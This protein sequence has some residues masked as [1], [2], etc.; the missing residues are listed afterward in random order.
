MCIRD[1]AGLM[2]IP[3]QAFYSASKFALEGFTEA[4]RMEVL[5]FGIRVVLIEP[6]DFKT[7]FTL[8]RTATEQSRQSLTYRE[9]CMKSL[10]VMEHDEQN[11]KYPLPV[12]HLIERIMHD[13]SP[14]LRYTIGPWSERLSPKLRAGLPYKIYERLFMK[15][16]KLT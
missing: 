8:N 6:G 13:L 14:R 2:G 3:F 10:A 11:G 7:H 16:F 9:S 1:R 4:L 5:Q 12:A 15:Y